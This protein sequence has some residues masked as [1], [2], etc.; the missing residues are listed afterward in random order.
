MPTLQSAGKVY[1]PTEV[2]ECLLLVADQ[3]EQPVYFEDSLPTKEGITNLKLQKMLFFAHAAHLALFDTPLVDED[4]EAWN[5]GPVLSTVYQRYKTFS[6]SPIPPPKEA[7]CT[8]EKL[9]EFLEEIWKIF[10]KYTASELVNLSHQK[11]SPWAKHF[12]PKI[13]HSIIP[14]D[15]IKNYYKSFFSVK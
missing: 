14:N 15:E 9:H 3:E 1:S 4:F 7:R 10:G 13:E 11:D 6:R 5:L 8:D 12:N 2:A